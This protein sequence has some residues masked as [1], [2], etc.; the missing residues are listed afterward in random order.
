MLKRE[1]E[2]KNAAFV[3]ND[4][5]LKEEIPGSL[6]RVLVPDSFQEMILRTRRNEKVQ[7]ELEL[8]V[9]AV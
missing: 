4:D 3:S 2:K 7:K 5:S 8:A 1:R 9:P 6:S